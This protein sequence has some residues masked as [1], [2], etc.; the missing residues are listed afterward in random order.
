MEKHL[1]FDLIRECFDFVFIILIRDSLKKAF[2]IFL[3]EKYML[4]SRNTLYQVLPKHDTD[5]IRAN[6]GSVVLTE[7]ES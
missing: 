2:Y 3:E 4:G 1:T 5:C 6:I 7:S